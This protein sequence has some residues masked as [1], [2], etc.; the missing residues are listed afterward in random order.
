[1]TISTSS[2]SL[3]NLRG[4]RSTLLLRGTTATRE[5]KTINN[6]KNMN[7]E[8]S[9]DTDDVDFD[10]EYDDYDDGRD[11]KPKVR[12]FKERRAQ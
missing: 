7:Q 1:M 12:K 10:D 9:T 2:T 11:Y 6:G 8:F 4:K 5:N 3:L